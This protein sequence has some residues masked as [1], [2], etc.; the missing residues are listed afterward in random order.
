MNEIRNPPL[1]ATLHVEVL[2]FERNPETGDV[3]LLSGNPESDLPVVPV[4]AEAA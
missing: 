3:R 4:Y 2:V 1:E